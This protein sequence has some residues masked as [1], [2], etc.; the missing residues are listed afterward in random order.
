MQRDPRLVRLSR[1]HHHAL[2]L[3]L[4]I[5]REL[6]AATEAE[7]RALYGDLLRFWAAGLFPHFGAENE[8]LLARIA[9]RADPGLQHAG[10]LQRDHREIEA[11]VETMRTTASTDER[12]EALARFG[13]TLREHVRWEESELFEWLQTTLDVAEL[14]AIG[15][16]LEA[17]LPAEPLAAPMPHDP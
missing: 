2:V 17:H 12:R 8:C 16:Y 10:R 5:Q 14:D 13:Q 4:R 6:P 11:L 1:E 3:A 15:E 9:G 7:M